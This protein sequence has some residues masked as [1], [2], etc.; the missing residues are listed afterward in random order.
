[1]R[2]LLGL[3]SALLT[4]GALDARAM[5]ETVTLAR[6][7]NATPT[8][9]VAE[10]EA[11]AR[12]LFARGVEL[13]TLRRL[14]QALQYFERAHA[15]HPDPRLL[16]T[17]GQ[18]QYELGQYARAWLTLRAYLTGASSAPE[19]RRRLVERQLVALATETAELRVDVSVPGAEISVDGEPAGVSP[20][21]E[22]IRLDPGSH[23]VVAKRAGFMASSSDVHLSRGESE[24]VALRLLP[25]PPAPPSSDMLRTGMWTVSAGCAVLALSA[26]VAARVSSS[27]YSDA[28]TRAY[29][30]PD[31]APARQ[32]LDEMR[33]LVQ[34][35]ALATDVFAA[36]ALVSGGVA[37]YLS[38][39]SRDAGPV[40]TSAR[41]PAVGVRVEY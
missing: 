6:P 18:V 34:A 5:D 33:D 16:F 15:L 8:P 40:P 21:A 11:L 35:F 13:H 14:P 22:P 30:G 20:R 37:V 32:R 38:L 39:E 24:R 26:A 1:M 36:A 9:V 7:V 3:A 31:I 28:R 10:A 17:I 4:C 25:P 23:R 27:D 19:E 2:R 41:A 12:E 29:D